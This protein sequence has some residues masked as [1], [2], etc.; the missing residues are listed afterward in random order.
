MIIKDS[1]LTKQQYKKPVYTNTSRGIIFGN[2]LNNDIFEH[3]NKKIGQTKISFMGVSKQIS[4]KLYEFFTDIEEV[5][6]QNNRTYGVAGNLPEE[7]LEHVPKKM[8]KVVINNVLAAFA[9]AADQLTFFNDTIEALHLMQKSEQ[10]KEIKLKV[11]QASKY[12]E[13]SFIETGIINAD[14]TIDLKFVGIGEFGMSYTFKVGDE[15]YSF[16]QFNPYERFTHKPDHPHGKLMEPNRAIF[17]NKLIKNKDTQFS[18]FYFADLKNAYM[19]TKYIDKDTPEPKQSFDLKSVGLQYG[20]DSSAKK[21]FNII[22]GHIVDY[23]GLLIVNTILATNKT[24]RWG[25]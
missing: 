25:L 12:L 16:K 1:L 2:H 24:A 18:K 23:G 19:V 14:D 21:D 13:T 5:L 4:N 17:L 11:Q 7:W 15:I 10:N 8:K 22:N 3:R 9:V 6:N 20:D